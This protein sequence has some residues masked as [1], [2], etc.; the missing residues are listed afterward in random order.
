MDMNAKYRRWGWGAVIALIGVILIAGLVVAVSMSSPKPDNNIASTTAAN[1][2]GGNSGTD[3]DSTDA[4]A[5]TE[6]EEEAEKKAEEEAKQKAEAEK[7]AEEEEKAAK[8]KA[9]AEK[10]AA[11]EKAAREQAAREEAAR[12]NNLPHTGPVDSMAAIVGFAIVAY[13]FALNVSL[14]K[15]Q[16]H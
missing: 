14:V 13:L 2:D 3:G 4:E 7:K 8:E 9:A 11:E 10:K 12:R 1:G 15:K 16:I 5:R 6:A